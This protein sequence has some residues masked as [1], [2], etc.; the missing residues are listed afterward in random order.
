MT[1][2][3]SRYIQLFASELR[4]RRVV[5]VVTIYVVTAWVVLQV[6]EVTF[7]PLGLPPWMMRS[8]IV[9]AVIGIPISALLAW[10]IDF[11]E[12]GLVLDLPLWVGD[13]DNPRSRRKS[14][15]VYAALLALLMA[16][17][18]Y[19]A[20]VMFSSP[21]DKVAP[22]LS[23]AQSP[24]N[25]IAV[26]AFRNFDGQR[27]SDFFALGLGEE[28]LNLLAGFEE[29]NVAARTSSFRFK[30]DEVDVREVAEILGVR[31][32]LEG[33]VRQ[34]Q[35]RIRV[36]A[37]LI[38]G[39]DGYHV[40]SKVYDRALTDIFAIQEEIASA[41]V[42]ELQI[43]LS[44]DSV[45]KLQQ[46]PTDD[47]DAYIFYLQG[48][49]RLNSS[50]DNDV[51]KTAVQLFEKAIGID[52]AFSRA[53]AGICE[54]HLRL[55][56]MAYDTEEFEHA[57]KACE[58]ASK[59]DAGLNGETY[60][61]M[62]RLYRYRGSE[63]HEQADQLLS[64]AINTFPSNPDAYIELGELRVVQ[65]RIDEAEPLFLR[66]V[67][68]KRNYWKAHEALAGFYYSNEEF[69]KAVNAYEV[70]S[71]LAP[72]VASVFGGKGA[73]YN[74]LGDIQS[75]RTAYE[76]SLELKPSRQA[77]TNTGLMFYYA[78]QFEDAAEMQKRALELAPDD[79]RVWGRLAES[80]RFVPGREVES[81]DA[82]R[83]AIQLARE[84]LDI[85]ANDW[86]TRGLLATYLVHSGEFEMAL[87][88]A[89]QALSESQR[90]REALYY[91]ALVQT[92]AGLTEDAL[93]TLEE[94][95]EGDEQYRKFVADDPD[96][97]VLRGNERFD[98]LI[99]P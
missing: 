74:M 41:V 97:Q 77:Y 60:L 61:A 31:H 12:K 27:D 25:S 14:D 59:L 86:R 50:L 82:Y 5:R 34:N 92:V 49:E 87:E 73:A 32:V 6:A 85:N 78:G 80:C 39:T 43:A 51:T 10:F 71:S 99:L 3:I 98:R 96:M 18:T 16:A 38:D 52:P 33:S 53:Y 29:L 20:I 76:R 28:I 58:E 90:N 36:T 63:W 48:R 66:A 42:N 30:N 94:T 69:Q 93:S 89:K 22:A 65:N 19:T 8:L 15:L 44:V 7:E 84:N 62:G 79:H 21:E 55:Y 75:A 17:L 37:Q 1:V 9:T 23:V 24:S 68:L 2:N 91:L 45:Q 70:A 40:W 35:E 26:L 83:R 4:R 72:D 95:V 13:R 67:D 11:T 57:R 47:I 54:A 88:Q 64:R 46:S 56:E 81:T